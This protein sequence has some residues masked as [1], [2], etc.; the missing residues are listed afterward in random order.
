MH[1]KS[2]K[3]KKRLPLPRLKQKKKEITNHVRQ[4]VS[5][6]LQNSGVQP[7]VIKKGTEGKRT[8]AKKGEQYEKKKTGAT[9][10]VMHSNSKNKIGQEIGH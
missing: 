6:N 3:R 8:G 7:S 4:R 2:Q 9:R 1:Q 10:G 5:Q